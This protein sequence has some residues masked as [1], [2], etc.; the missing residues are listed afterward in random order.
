MGVPIQF[1]DYSYKLHQKGDHLVHYELSDSDEAADP[2]YYGYL[3]SDGGWLIMEWNMAA[4]T[5]RYCAG[6]TPAYKTALTGA[7]AKRADPLVIVYV[8]YNEI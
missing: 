7:W 1:L 6:T 5:Y 3:N 2:H 4:G 8:Y